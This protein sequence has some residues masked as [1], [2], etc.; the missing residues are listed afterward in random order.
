[1][2]SKTFTCT[3]QKTQDSHKKKQNTTTFFKT[4]SLLR[5]GQP[6]LCRGKLLCLKPLYLHGSVLIRKA[7]DTEHLEVYT[8]ANWSSDPIARESTSGGILKIGTTSLREFTK[9]QSCQTLS[10]GEGEYYAAVTTTAEALHLQKLLELTGLPIKLRL[11]IDSQQHV[12]S[13]K[14]KGVY[15]SSILR[16]DPFGFKRNTRRES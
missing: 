8:D 2:K 10:S 3:P 14:D 15:L 11:R 6:L 5:N 7:D 1:M 12:E 16:R 4:T 9:G 13:S